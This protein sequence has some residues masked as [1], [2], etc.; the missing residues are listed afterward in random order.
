M[1]LQPL[2]ELAWPESALVVMMGY[3]EAGLQAE[4]MTDFEKVQTN[5]KWGVFAGPED[6]RRQYPI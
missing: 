4:P 6:L 3:A 1:G 5:R 2:K